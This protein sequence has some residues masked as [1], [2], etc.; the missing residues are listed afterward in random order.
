MEAP[1]FNIDVIIYRERLSDTL[2]LLRL[3]TTYLYGV[4]VY[5][6]QFFKEIFRINSILLIVLTIA[7]L[8]VIL[9]Y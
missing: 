7:V 4:L 3:L 2:I 6:I 9:L 8:F 5:G 1:C